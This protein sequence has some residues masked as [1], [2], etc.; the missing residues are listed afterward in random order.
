MSLVKIPVPWRGMNLVGEPDALASGQGALVLNALPGRT[1]QLVPRGPAS[2]TNWVLPVSNK[3]DVLNGAGGAWISPD[4]NGSDVLM[5]AGAGAT[6]SRSGGAPFAIPGGGQITASHERMNGYTVGCTDLVNGFLV[7]WDGATTLTR[8]TNGPQNG[9]AVEGHL[10]RLFVLIQ[11][12]SGVGYELRWTDPAPDLPTNTAALWQDDA[13]GL[14]N[15]I[16]LPSGDWYRDIVVFN[17]TL[18]IIAAQAVYALTGD[19]PATFA[20][21]RVLETGAGQRFGFGNDGACTT[22]GRGVYFWSQDGVMRWDGATSEVVSDPIRPLL[23]SVGYQ[24]L[25]SL[26][27]N[28]VSLVTPGSWLVLH[29]PS[30]AWVK[31]SSPLLPA[32]GLHGGIGGLPTCV[33]RRGD[34]WTAI[35]AG[36]FST[37]TPGTGIDLGKCFAPDPLGANVFRSTPDPVTAGASFRDA[38]T[39]PYS[40]SALSGSVRVSSPDKLAQ[41]K[42]LFAQAANGGWNVQLEDED[43]NVIG[44]PAIINPVTYHEGRSRAESAVFAE[45]DVV[46]AR[47][48]YMGTVT[49]A[50]APSVGDAYVLTEAA[51]QR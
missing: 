51:Q 1:G 49:R 31:M 26:P 21:R 45:V 6:V 41:L 33:R 42:R 29:E 50:S 47:F 24:Q 32:A 36:Q 22:T 15:K 10:A 18:Y 28:F 23:D 5:M 8:I 12:P 43:S 7:T 17:R 27:N 40:V 39:T 25:Q 38:G 2:K 4:N 34:K 44:P 46:R 3:D 11:T 35:S 16:T 14:T 48:T 19:T 9:F 37:G 30:G 20:I 13:S